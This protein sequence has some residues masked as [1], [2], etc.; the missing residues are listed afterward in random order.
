MNI[1]FVINKLELGGAETFL[2]RLVKSL[3]EEFGIMPFLYCV[4][5]SK[6]NLNFEKYF[7]DETRIIKIST[8]RNPTGIFNW[9]G[10]KINAIFYK[11]FKVS[12]Y[13]NYLVKRKKNYFKSI[14]LKD[15]IN[16]INS[17]LLGA[18][19]FVLENIFPLAE[20]PWVATSQGCY[21]DLADIHF[22]KE[23]M[24]AI[25]GLTFVAEKN[26]DFFN[27]NDINIVENSRLIYNG[28]PKPTKD[29]T[30]ARN[31]LGFA[32]DDIVLI[33]VSR[34]IPSK[35]M[36]ESILATMLAGKSLNTSKLKLLIVGPENEY[37]SELKSKYRDLD[38]VKFYGEHLKPIEL[39]Q[40]ADI[41]ILPSFFH[42]ESCPSTIIEYLA[43]GKP[44]VSTVLGEIPNMI[45]FN[46]ETA[47]ILV[48][49]DAETKTP[50][51]ES[52]SESIFLLVSN[53]DLYLRK[54]EIALK[55]FE[56]F[57]IAKSSNL[58]LEVYKNAILNYE[59]KN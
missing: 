43:V 51:V 3:K 57:E 36:E 20:I 19:S 26:L 38:F 59:R 6:G 47:G 45:K 49:L 54:S 10:W 41:G 33:H 17:H 4:E 50:K 27:L 28:I 5:P 11:V 39:V 30:I 22:A 48:E 46:D 15:R 44:I 56:K 13:E 18:D 40:C 35:G 9:V 8:Y 58:Y 25:N 29:S 24:S 32:E 12:P 16:L 37:Y 55:A 1:L 14:L 52:L 53:T 42:G 31:E 7:L 23:L 2:L 34:S 21:N